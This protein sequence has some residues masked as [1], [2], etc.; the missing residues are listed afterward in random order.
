MSVSTQARLQGVNVGAH[1]AA[2]T[3]ALQNGVAPLQITPQA[4]QPDASLAR[5]TQAPAHAT[6]A[7]A[8]VQRPPTHAR[9]AAQTVPHAPQFVGSE[10]RA[11]H[12]S[13]HADSPVTEQT[14][15]APPSPRGVAPGK[16]SDVVPPH[17]DAIT[18]AASVAV[19]SR[20]VLRPENDMASIRN[21]TMT[22]GAMA[23]PTLVLLIVIGAS[24]AERPQGST[25]SA[26]VAD[27]LG[28]DARVLVEERADDPSDAEAAALADA[29]RGSA[30]AEIS[31]ADAGHA[32][33]RLHVYLASDRSWY[34]RDVSFDRADALAER[35]RAIGFVV[36]AMIRETQGMVLPPAARTPP[37]IPTPAPPLISTSTSAAEV[38]A[39]PVPREEERR[40][41]ADVAAVATTGIDGDAPGLGPSF[42]GHVF[43]TDALSLHAGASLGFGSIEAADARMSTTR[44]VA[45]GRA[46]WLTVGRDLSFDL[47]ID[48]LAVHHAVHRAEPFADRSRWLAGAHTDF[49]LAWRASAFVEPFATAGVDAV[50][51]N[52]PIAVAGIRLAQIPPLRA[53]FELGVKMRF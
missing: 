6:V 43:V 15:A 26:A 40:F 14:S 5:S 49:G 25:V 47:G 23:D 51:G 39:R 2:H 18:A 31:W 53:V 29:I 24:A 22:R 42:R 4:P 35:E 8:H 44:I 37:V 38:D 50:L 7:A 10:R 3:P 20:L 46:R 32:R 17:A 28:R 1:D 34:D 13:P 30:V 19:A 21:S 11:A 16:S 12:V 52:T 41:G 27:A 9:D 45:G 48:A 33:A 36:G